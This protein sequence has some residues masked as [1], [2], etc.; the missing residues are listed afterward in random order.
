MTE[1]EQLN[2]RFPF[3]TLG[4]YMGEDI[5]GIMQNMDNSIISI[6]VYGKIPSPELKKKFLELG[7][8]WWWESNR[9]I[10]INMFLGDEIKLFS[11]YMQTFIAK[12]FEYILGPQVSLDNL[13]SKRVKRR[14]IQLIRKI[15]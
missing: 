13:M 1:F 10:P 9:K 14:S 11:P 3:L 2:S 6:Y 4:R 15:K 12:E 5:V 8:T 7:E